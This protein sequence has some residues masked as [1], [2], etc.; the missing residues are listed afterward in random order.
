MAS[1]ERWAVDTSVAVAALDAGHGAHP[2]CLA[3]V[4]RHRPALAGHAAYELF[5]VLTRM[6]GSLA[7]DPVDAAALIERVFPEVAWLSVADSQSLRAR[8]APLGIVGG[9]VY[10]ALVGEAARAE[11][12]RL[13][14]RDLRARRTYD[15]IGVDYLIVGS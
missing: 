9:A 2:A 14:T 3:A 4:R 11:R 15:L 7:I 6:P 8:L 13:L 10:D 5:A 1:A 12:R